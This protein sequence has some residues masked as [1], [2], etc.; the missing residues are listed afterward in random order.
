LTE[1]PGMS[2]SGI[3]ISATAPVGFAVNWPNSTANSRAVASYT[4]YGHSIVTLAAPGGDSALPGNAICSIPRTVGPPVTNF[5]WVFDLVLSP[6]SQS[7][8]YFFAAGTSMAAPHVSGVA[9]LVKQRFPGISVGDLKA[10][11]QQTADDEGANGADPFYG[12]GFVNA[13]RA[14]TE[15]LSL[16]TNDPGVESVTPSASVDLSIARKSGSRIP[17]ITF[18]THKAGPV[19]VDLFDLAGRNVVTLYNGVAAAGR[20]MVTWNG[21]GSR[22]QELSRGA[23]FARVKADG[24][25]A[26]RKMILLDQ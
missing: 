25:Q 7:G 3:A 26:V 1:A 6:G 10:F 8:S 19:R 12:H 17:E 9:A 5:C 13:H 23:Y 24:A 15:P 21:R 11:L 14:V 18:A 20:T 4:N 16:T 2:G 22:G